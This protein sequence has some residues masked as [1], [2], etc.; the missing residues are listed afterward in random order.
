MARPK[1]PRPERPG[2]GRAVRLHFMELSRKWAYNS[3]VAGVVPKG[4]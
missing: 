3:P 2:S 1:A 4:P